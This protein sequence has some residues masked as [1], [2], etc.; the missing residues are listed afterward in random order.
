MMVYDV[1]T[2]LP[3]HSLG[4][5]VVALA[6]LGVVL[7]HLISLNRLLSSTPEDFRKLTPDRW[8]REQIQTTYDRLAEQ[9]IT[10]EAYAAQLPPRLDRRYIVTGGS[11]IVGGYIVLHLLAR[12]QP[13]ETIRIVDFQRPHRA[14]MLA[15]GDS[16][17][18]IAR[19]GFQRA[20]ISSAEATDA[21]FA[22]PWPS[23]AIADLPLTVFHTAAVI[24]PSARDERV[25]GFC[26]AVNVR[27][28]A[29]V[30]AAARRAGAD[31]FVSTSSASIAIRP[32]EF[33]G[34]AGRAG[35]GGF[36]KYYAQVL[37]ETDFFA[38]PVRPHAEFFGN[39]PASKAHGERLVCGA[40]GPEMRTGCIRPANGVYGHPSDNLLGAPLNMQTYPS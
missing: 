24:V 23:A 9:P 36:P 39:Y 25:K 37:D 2:S 33:W 12:G 5:A 28:T 35:P 6:L 3:A 17:A 21:A 40:N 26:E 32:V 14:D 7:L 31:V 22:A 18:A 15:G 1:L 8:T 20:D 30:L 38:G 29:H 27:G 16:D 13:P 19:V 10:T 34:G 4:A 11:G